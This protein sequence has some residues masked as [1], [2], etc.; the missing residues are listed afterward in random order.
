M[1]RGEW[2]EWIEWTDGGVWIEWV[3]WMEWTVWMETVRLRLRVN[4]VIRFLIASLRTA[5]ARHGSQER[6]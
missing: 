4:R 6:T 3:K 5:P 2:T 1:K